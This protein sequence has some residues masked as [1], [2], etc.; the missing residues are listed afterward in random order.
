MNEEEENSQNKLELKVN[1]SY[2]NSNEYEYV[3]YMERINFDEEKDEDLQKGKGFVIS[4]PRATI[5][6]DI[7]NPN[8]I[9][10]EKFGQKLGDVNPFM[11]RYSCQCGAL[12]SRINHGIECEKCHTICKYVDDD[13][14]MFGWIELKQEYPIINPDIYKQLDSLFGKSKYDRNNKKKKGSKLKNIIEYDIIIDQDGNESV[15]RIDDPNEPFYGIGMIEF[16]ERFDEILEF[17]YGK[18]TKKKDVYDDIVADRDKIFIN[19]IP[20]FTTHLR[21]MDINANSM[22]FEKC[23]GIY[24]MMVRLS[25][26]INKTNTRFATTPKVKN[27][28]LFNLQMKYIE[29]YDEI[30][31]ILSGKKGQLRMLIG[32]RFN[33]SS[34]SVIKQD[35]MLRIDQLK[36]PYVE[37]VITMEQQIINILHRTY[38]ISY[39][40]AYDKWY[41]SIATKD[42][43]VAQIIDTIIHST[44]VG[45][46]PEDYGIPIIF[47]R[48]PTINYGSILQMQ[49]VGYNDDYT[50]SVPLQILAPL[51]AD[52]D[53]D[54]LNVFH[55]LNQAF[56]ERAYQVFNPRNAMYI[57]R[58]DGL[59]NMAVLVQRDTLINANTL[60]G[61]SRNNYT[62]EELAEIKALK[63]NAA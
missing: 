39:Q 5:K 44:R 18:N 49:C 33:F 19:S 59:L 42:E 2:P 16:H 9:F 32:G 7:K 29:L 28:L 26:K 48:N 17:Y 4:S 25:A 61:L 12:K 10:S 41:R 1:Y 43:T 50:I 51:A 63:N 21:P 56:F 38:N 53:G 14:S 54:T 62:E 52:F 11:D 15:Q 24:N 46:G 60:V 36:L 30:V 55:I 27:Q 45:D 47:N 58:N 23:T 20:V 6:K 31:A 40:D 13:F 37:L 8:G 34:R 22:Y 35:P 3:S 57:S